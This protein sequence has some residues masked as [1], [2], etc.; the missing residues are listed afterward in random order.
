MQTRSHTTVTVYGG[1]L[2]ISSWGSDN[3]SVTDSQGDQISIAG[4]EAQQ[5]RD[6]ITSYVR[7]LRHSSDSEK[8]SAAKWLALL[9][10]S[11]SETQER[12]TPSEAAV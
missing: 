6:A 8:T 9:A 2:N 5:I 3:I 12:L 7:S 11:V 1:R 10:D 4:V